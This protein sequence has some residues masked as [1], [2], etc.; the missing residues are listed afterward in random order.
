MADFPRPRPRLRPGVFESPDLHGKSGIE[1][2][3]T[4]DDDALAT[5]T[6]AGTT[7]LHVAILRLGAGSARG[8]GDVAAAAAT[9]VELDT[10]ALAGDAVAFAAALHG[11]ITH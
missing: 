4:T 2:H 5:G 11:G 1:N 3:L 10:V 8:L 7:V 6:A 9:A